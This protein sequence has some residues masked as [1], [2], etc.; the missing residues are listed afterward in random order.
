MSFAKNMGKNSSNKYSQNLLDTAKKSPPDAIKT[1]SKR[2]IHKTTGAA[3]Y[4]IGNKIADEITNLLKKSSRHSQN[5]EA[6]NEIEIPY[7][8]QI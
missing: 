1:D 6:N 4:L 3:V 5:D 7:K 2:A 8:Y